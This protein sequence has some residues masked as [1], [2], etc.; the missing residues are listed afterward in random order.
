MNRAR[1]NQTYEFKVFRTEDG[2]LT[3]L[4]EGRFYPL[5]EYVGERYGADPAV[6]TVDS[7]STVPGEPYTYRIFIPEAGK[8][9]TVYARRVDVFSEISYNVEEDPVFEYYQLYAVSQKYAAPSFDTFEKTERS[10][11]LAAVMDI[12]PG[13]GQLY[14][15][16]TFKGFVLLGSE[17]ALGAVALFAQTKSLYY[18]DV[19]EHATS[20]LD[21]WQ[22]NITAMKRLRNIS[23][24]AMA[25]VCA[26][27]IFDAIVADSVPRI[28]VSAPSGASLSLAPASGSAGAALVFQF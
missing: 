19:K 20:E 13:A 23:L 17:V 8:T 14:K 10:R 25:G 3:R 1:T 9:A 27:G 4:R 26:F 24:C 11:T 15:G 12:V 2:N 21:S 7:L 18:K 22:S 16:D 5:L 6:M 28:V